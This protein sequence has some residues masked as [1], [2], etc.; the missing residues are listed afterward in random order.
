LLAPK[1][2]SRYDLITR[3]NIFSNLPKFTPPKE[4]KPPEK[5]EPDDNGTGREPEPPPPPKE[6]TFDLVLNG[7][8]YLSSDQQWVAQIE[9]M[10]TGDTYFVRENDQIGD[11]ITIRQIEADAVI[12]DKKDEEEPITL[13]LR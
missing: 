4:V 1:P 2:V 6:P 3:R 11:D 10:R 8:I 9:N 12:L 5:V 7:T 13:K